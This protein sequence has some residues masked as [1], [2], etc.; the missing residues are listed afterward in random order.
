MGV[1]GASVGSLEL[2]VT[3]ARILIVR[4]RLPNYHAGYAGRELQHCLK[5][6]KMCSI[7]WA[8]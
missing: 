8:N 5:M 3:T 1:G 6:A 4:E 7:Y 2:G